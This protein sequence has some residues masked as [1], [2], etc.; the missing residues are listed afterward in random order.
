MYRS[1]SPLYIKFN[2]RNCVLFLNGKYNFQDFR[3]HLEQISYH[4]NVWIERKIAIIREKLKFM[5]GVNVS[6]ARVIAWNLAD[7]DSVVSSR[8][9]CARRDIM[10]E[11]CGSCNFAVRGV[12]TRLDKSPD[13]HL[14]IHLTS[15]TCP[16]IVIVYD[17]WRS[18]KYILRSLFLP[19]SS[20]LFL[21][22]FIGHPKFLPLFS[23]ERYC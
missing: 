18:A 23:S 17:T 20:L 1:R 3:T 15:R 11:S 2:E 22:S 7:V 19:S 14:W 6:C 13:E 4:N 10:K 16:Q 8:R 9:N 21:F 5:N 12:I